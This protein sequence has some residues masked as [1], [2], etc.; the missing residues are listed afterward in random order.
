MI[1]D[2][3]PNQKPLGMPSRNVFLFISQFPKGVDKEKA[4][5]VTN[6]R[7]NRKKKN[8]QCDDVMENWRGLRGRP[9]FTPTRIE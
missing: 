9:K 7:I 4:R 3:F 8:N 1:R 2:L 5:I 6:L